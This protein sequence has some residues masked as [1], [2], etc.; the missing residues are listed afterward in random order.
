MQA[1]ACSSLSNAHLLVLAV[2]RLCSTKPAAMSRRWMAL[3]RKHVKVACSSLIDMPDRCLH[4]QVRQRVKACAQ[5]MQR[6][7]QAASWAC[8]AR[9]SCRKRHPRTCEPRSRARA[10]RSSSTAPTGTQRTPSSAR[11]VRTATFIRHADMCFN[12]TLMTYICSI[13]LMQVELAFQ[14]G[15]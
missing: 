4:A 9:S 11:H 12:C 1:W 5:G 14:R 2:L 7:M 10:R 13:R 3:S 15:P 8:R 6:R